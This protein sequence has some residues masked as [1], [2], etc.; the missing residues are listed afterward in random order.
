MLT[1]TAALMADGRQ[2]AV[3]ARKNEAM[4][5]LLPTA[6]WQWAGAMGLG[7]LLM[8]ASRRRIDPA[9]GVA[10]SLAV[11]A[12]AAWLA[13]VPWPFAG[14]R[15]FD[16]ARIDVAWDSR[17]RD[18]GPGARRRRR[19]GAASSR[20][21]R[22]RDPVLDAAAPAQA[23]SSR[24]GYAGLVLATGLGWLLLL[25]LSAHAH[26]GNRYLALYHQGHLWLGLL[27]FSLLLF[28]R[29]P[30]AH[31]LAWSLSIAGEAARAASQRLGAA[32]AA[33][34]IGAAG[35][36]GRARASASPSPT[37]AS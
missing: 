21:L 32:G 19:A 31:G 1:A 24:I 18:L 35:D 16:P 9:L 23:M 34:A 22:R 11:W 10:L 30:L 17:A 5:E 13:R 36:A 33:A 28:L 7:F 12:A 6:G 14:S 20:S 25:D 8:L 26:R 15:G 27:V 2:S 37:C 3:R 29:R 4:R